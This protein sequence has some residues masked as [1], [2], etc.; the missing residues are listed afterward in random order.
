MKAKKP[1]HMPK[2]MP[3]NGYGGM[4]GMGEM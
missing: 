1:S 4:E 2:E 3:T